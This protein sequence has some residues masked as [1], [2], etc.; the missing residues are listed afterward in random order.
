MAENNDVSPPPVLK[1]KQGP[2]RR[3]RRALRLINYPTTTEVLRQVYAE[4]TLLISPVTTDE[5][6]PVPVDSAVVSYDDR[7]KNQAKR[8]RACRQDSSSI[9]RKMAQKRIERNVRFV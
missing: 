7:L 6:Q 1:T 8:N 2:N 9:R 4:R 5:T 3:Q